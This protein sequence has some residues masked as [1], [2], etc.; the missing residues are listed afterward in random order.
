MT[1]TLKG[2]GTK[3]V[4]FLYVSVTWSDNKGPEMW[5]KPKFIGFER[6]AGKDMRSFFRRSKNERLSVTRLFIDIV[7]I[8]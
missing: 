8:Q 5:I 1:E 4:Y 7:L 6:T 3:C 2:N